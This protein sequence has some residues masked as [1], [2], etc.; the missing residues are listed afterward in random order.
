V[1]LD[2]DSVQFSSDDEEVEEIDTIDREIVAAFYQYGIEVNR[3]KP[4]LED[5][6]TPLFNEVNDIHAPSFQGTALPILAIPVT[7]GRDDR[8]MPLLNDINASVP[9]YLPKMA[10]P[11]ALIQI[12]NCIVPN[13][14]IH[15]ELSHMGLSDG[16]CIY[17]SDFRALYYRYAHLCT[18]CTITWGFA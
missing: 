18:H 5:M 10:I 15:Q 3:P 6:H 4:S 16:E 9:A 1:C 8:E 2:Q 7:D 12:M 11:A 17:L 14:A 13:D